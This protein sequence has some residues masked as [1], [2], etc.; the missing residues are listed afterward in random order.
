MA[1]FLKQ[2]IHPAGGASAPAPA[3]APTPRATAQS[4]AVQEQIEAASTEGK[5][6]W[7]EEDAPKP[8]QP[9][10]TASRSQ[11]GSGGGVAADMSIPDY[12][13]PTPR[14]WRKT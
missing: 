3:P 11:G 8:E 1:T 14:I 5:H 2:P 9:S 12:V 10:E 7:L 13:G 4:S 6:E